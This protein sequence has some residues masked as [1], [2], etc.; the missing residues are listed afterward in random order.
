MQCL[1]TTEQLYK[2]SLQK[3]ASD[4]VNLLKSQHGDVKKELESY[5]VKFNEVDGDAFRKALAPLY[6][7]QEGMT[8]GILKLSLLN[9][10]LCDNSVNV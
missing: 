3:G 8:P 5:G 1:K 10:I 7:E 2:K 9:S 6:A 4:M